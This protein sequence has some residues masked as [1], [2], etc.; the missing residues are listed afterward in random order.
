M[1]GTG[2]GGSVRGRRKR[3]PDGGR[4]GGG[5]VNGPNIGA[6]GGGPVKRPDSGLRDAQEASLRAGGLARQPPTGWEAGWV[7]GPKT[8]CQ[9]SRALVRDGSL[10]RQ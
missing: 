3:Q 6:G 4:V 10:L 1:G 2:F 7:G 5:L 9:G 8:G